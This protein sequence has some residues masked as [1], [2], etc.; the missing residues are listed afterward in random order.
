MV[1]VCFCLCGETT[2]NKVGPKNYE[3]TELQFKSFARTL[4]N[5]KISQ[6]KSAVKKISNKD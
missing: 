5:T 3:W 1:C 4:T 2:K 6:Q